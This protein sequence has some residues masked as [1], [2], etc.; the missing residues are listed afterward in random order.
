MPEGAQPPI[1][2]KAS[3]TS[4]SQ[5]T[6]EGLTFSLPP[7]F[8]PAADEMSEGASPFRGAG[9]TTEHFRSYFDGSGNGIFFLCWHGPF[10]R[11]RGAM[12]V[13]ERWETQVDGQPATISLTHTFFGRKQRVLVAHFQSPEPEPHRYMIY[14]TR[15]DREMFEAMLQGARFAAT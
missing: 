15:V 3:V 1:R 12:A 7:G 9:L 10:V 4:S 8:S 5:Q 14:T 6:F 11:D 2:Q 13:E